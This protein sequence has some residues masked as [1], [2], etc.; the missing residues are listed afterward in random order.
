M[1]LLHND[2]TRR[3]YKLNNEEKILITKEGLEERKAELNRLKT[4]GR[5]EIAEKIKIA[6]DFGDLS[7][8]AEYDEAKLEQGQM[9][10]RIIEL[11]NTI[12]NAQIIEEDT[13]SGRVSL[14]STVKLYDKEFKEDLEY[15]IV[16]S[17]EADPIKGLISNVSPLGKALL[18]SQ[19][20]QIVVAD[21]P[22]GKMEFEVLEIK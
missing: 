9:E 5:K 19:E 20:G 7:E 10:D 6:R 4:T 2:F 11:E 13:D 21:T 1:R 18:G 14:G 17:E 16:G 12:K 22:S 15:K 8:N 3:E